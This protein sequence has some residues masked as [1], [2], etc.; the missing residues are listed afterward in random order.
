[1]K[2][3]SKVFTFRGRPNENIVTHLKWCRA[4]MGERGKGWD[5]H[6]AFTNT[7]IEIWDQQ[8]LTMYIMWQG[9]KSDEFS[10]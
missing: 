4:N 3:G 1:M 6:G 8:L 10:K 2:L 9:H 5:F 7:Q